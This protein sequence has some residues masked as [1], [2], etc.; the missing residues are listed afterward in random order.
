MKI[1]QNPDKEYANDI[2][3][4]LKANNGYCPC[5]LIK[6]ANTKCPCKMFREQI[7]RGEPGACHCGLW[8]A[9]EE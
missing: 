4:R 9:S 6:D 1:T 5:Q 2:K 7:D 3:K 8:V